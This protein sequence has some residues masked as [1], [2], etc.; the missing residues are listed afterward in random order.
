MKGMACI[1]SGSGLGSG[2]GSGLGLGLGLGLGNGDGVSSVGL[3]HNTMQ[4]KTR[5]AS[6]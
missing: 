4:D 5:A 1:S 2:S 6:S 3:T